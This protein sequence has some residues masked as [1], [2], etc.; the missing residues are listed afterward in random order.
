[1]SY[2]PTEQILLALR[3]RNYKEADRLLAEFRAQPNQGGLDL[4]EKDVSGKTAL[5]QFANTSD[6][7]Q[8]AWL[9]QAGANLNAQDVQGN[10]PLFCAV[11]DN[12]V[13]AI[14]KLL[15]LGADPDLR[16][17]RKIAPILQ[18]VLNHQNKGAAEALLAAG[19]FPDPTTETQTT[20]LLAATS[21]GKPEL[22]KLLLEKGA[23]PE[24]ADY[25]GNGLL[26]AA[27]TSGKVETLQIIRAGSPIPLD[28]NAPARSGTTPMS[29]AL[30]QPDMLEIL[31]AMGG[32]P[33][34]KVVNRISDGLTLLT[35][36]VGQVK[37][38]LPIKGKD[39]EA[40]NTGNPFIGMGGGGSAA[41]SHLA[42]VKDMLSKGADPKVRSDNGSNSGAS[43]VQNLDLL[44]ALVHAGLD[45]KRPLD[46][47]SSL[48]YD[49]LSANVLDR[50]DPALVDRIDELK[51]LGFPFQRPV[52]DESLDGPKPARH[53]AETGGQ[54]VK[55]AP[56]P[57]LLY[58]AAD[59]WDGVR[60]L[61]D[62][63]ANINTVS[64]DG[65]GIFHILAKNNVNGMTLAE[66]TGIAMAS[67]SLSSGQDKMDVQKLKDDIEQIKRDSSWRVDTVVADLLARH[68]DPNLQDAKGN[69]PLHLAAQG[70]H[71]EWITRLVQLPG[72]D[73]GLRNAE[74]LSVAG[75]ALR[76]GH[77]EL[78]YALVKAAESKG[79]DLRTG[80][81]A[82]TV[83]AAHDDFRARAS[84]RAAVGSLAET[85]PLTAQDATGASAD[86][87]ENPLLVAVTEEMEDVV[88]ILLKLGANPNTRDELGNTVLMTAVYSEHGENI[89]L[90]RAAGADPT[91][92][93]QNGENAFDV[94]NWI[95]S[96]Y[97]HKMLDDNDGLEALATDVASPVFRQV[98]ELGDRQVAWLKGHQDLIA[99]YVQGTVKREALADSEYDSPYQV[100]AREQAEKQRAAVEAKAAEKAAAMAQLDPNGA[101]AAAP[102]VTADTSA[103]P[104]KRPSP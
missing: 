58:A 72:I 80:L 68:A 34:T 39:E 25:M 73:L 78:T 20:P 52:W 94:A 100:H 57:I 67:R 69:T 97:V 21:H 71:V 61:N 23:N 30:G 77:A 89:R 29:A 63:G 65:V 60:R 59:W 18:A 76:A 22:V 24:A 12:D 46:L 44:K 93:N 3:D 64:A 47:N 28:A 85:L 95:K 19:A 49:I 83:L 26:I 14:K 79:V 84:W 9:A 101:P 53:V 70:G 16:N 103:P 27:V 42:L 62:L 45:P 11:T 2:T 91:L 10:T 86:P 48:P 87:Q 75:V 90:L 66:K 33:N 81:L 74:G 7:D 32:N 104:A 1:M 99:G 13:P 55:L 82:D 38:D 50:D 51:G 41:D 5:F 37:P 15:E 43:A 102:E 96:K 4:E 6:T 92:A 98:D 40:A 36:V 54:E 56:D 88:R 35:S 8:L 17:H 31:I